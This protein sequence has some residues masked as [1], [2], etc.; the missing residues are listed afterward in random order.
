MELATR[1]GF[2]KRLASCHLEMIAQSIPFQRIPFYIRTRFLISILYPHM[3]HL[4]NNSRSSG[5]PDV[6]WLHKQSTYQGHNVVQWYF[7]A[8]G[9][10]H[11]RLEHAV[12]ET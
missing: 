5:R 1:S 10:D 12:E 3:S 7:N 11:V 2:D 9:D 4:L 8:E 6:G